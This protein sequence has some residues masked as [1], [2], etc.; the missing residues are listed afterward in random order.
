MMHYSK[1]D[2]ST[3]FT[4]LCQHEIENGTFYTYE[5]VDNIPTT[6]YK[7]KL[8]MFYTE[9]EKTNIIKDITKI[10]ENSL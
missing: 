3:T 6:S 8:N 1:T 10:I 5:S 7:D 9:I 4:K 2:Y